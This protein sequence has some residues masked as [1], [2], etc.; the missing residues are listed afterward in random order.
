MEVLVEHWQA[1]EGQQRDFVCD[2]LSAP[3]QG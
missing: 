1:D 2:R 3:V